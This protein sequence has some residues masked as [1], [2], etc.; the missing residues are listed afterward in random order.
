MRVEI[1][2][3]RIVRTI[4]YP[5]GYPTGFSLEE[6][7]KLD[8]TLRRA[9]HCPPDCDGKHDNGPTKVAHEDFGGP[10]LIWRH[11]EAT[12]DEIEA[13]PG[14]YVRPFE[15]YSDEARGKIVALA[16]TKAKG[17]SGEA[18]NAAIHGAFKE[19]DCG[20]HTTFDPNRHAHWAQ[21]DGTSGYVMPVEQI[22][23]DVK[24]DGTPL[25]LA[26]DTW[27]WT[28]MGDWRTAEFKARPLTQ[29]EVDAIV[30]AKVQEWTAAQPV[31]ARTLEL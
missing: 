5:P 22:Q 28:E 31:P 23:V 30:D 7:H 9:A 21:T 27:E 10:P 3:P 6:M 2:A 1:F 26:I 16:K 15:T 14:Y 19:L 18:R 13:N 17:K 8:L 12:L 20:W 4:S 29:A 24:I 25:T 11:E